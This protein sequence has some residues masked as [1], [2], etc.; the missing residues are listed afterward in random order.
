LSLVK[1]E[2]GFPGGDRS[3]WHWNSKLNSCNP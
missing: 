1:L 2:F 3:N